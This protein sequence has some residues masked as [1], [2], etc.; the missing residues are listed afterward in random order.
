LGKIAYD[1]KVEQSV[2][3]GKSLLDVPPDSLAYLSVKKIMTKV[4]YAKE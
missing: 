2:L 1:E 4:G 3:E